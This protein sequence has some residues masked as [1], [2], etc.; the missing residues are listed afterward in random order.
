MHL[1]LVTCP[2]DPAYDDE[3]LGVDD[4]LHAA[5]RA[6]GATVEAPV[7]SDPDVDWSSYDLAFVRTTWDYP[8][9][10]DAF[11]AWAAATARVTSVWNRPDVLR[12]NTHKSYLLELE[13]RGA[14]VVPTAWLGRGDRVPLGDLLA[15]RGWKRAVVKPAVAAGSEGLVRVAAEGGEPVPDGSTGAPGSSDLATG[16]RHLDAL[17]AVGDVMVQPY[18]ESIEVA[19]ELSV[20]VID[21]EVSHA[22]RKI[23]SAGEFRIQSHYGGRYVA[24]PVDAEVAAL[25]RWIVEATGVELLA[26]RV[27]LLAADDG[28]L[29]LAELEATEPDLYLGVVPEAAERLADAVVARVGGTSAS[30]G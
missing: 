15:S 7:W 29:Q 30:R 4:A 9:A 18:L 1:A 5:L 11:V 23:P 17:L 21:G 20:V 19:G 28:A 26:A 6:R 12:W 14:P 10:R 25:A 16:Q 3:L 13:E 24:E 2:P 22:V 8:A 27:D